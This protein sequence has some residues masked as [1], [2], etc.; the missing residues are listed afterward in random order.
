MKQ[1]R[2]HFIPTPRGEVIPPQIIKADQFE[3]KDNMYH[4]T[5][6]GLVAVKNVDFVNRIEEV[7]VEK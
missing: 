4:F 2:V 7:G 5:A 3:R 6:T 1:F